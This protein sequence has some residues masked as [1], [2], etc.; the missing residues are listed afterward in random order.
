[1]K[2]ASSWYFLDIDLRRFALLLNLGGTKRGERS[3]RPVG[4]EGDDLLSSCAGDYQSPLR[5]TSTALP[6]GM[7]ATGMG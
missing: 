7:D 3:Q 4:L 2:W 5:P 6:T 1:M